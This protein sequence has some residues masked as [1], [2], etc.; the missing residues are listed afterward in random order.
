MRVHL[1]KMAKSAIK[2]L[3]DIKLIINGNEKGIP[4]LEG[5]PFVFYVIQYSCFLQIAEIQG[6]E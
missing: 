4:S 2:S 6:G 5:I 1:L 3:T